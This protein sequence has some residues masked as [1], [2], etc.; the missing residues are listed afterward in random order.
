MILI[1]KRQKK[2]LSGAMRYANSTVYTRAN[3]FPEYKGMG[4]TADICLFAFDT[5]YICHV[6]DGRVYL[7][8]DGGLTRLT[9]DHTLIEELLKNG[10][11]TEEEAKAHPNRHIITR[12]VGTDEKVEG[13]FTDIR[14]CDGDTV[15]MCTDGLT[16]MLSNEDIMDCL[17][18]GEPERICNELIFRS[19]E[20]GGRD[21]ITAV[22]IKYQTDEEEK[23]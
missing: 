9:T 15:L 22:V 8:R 10:T 17:S 5:L 13:D 18:L 3:A 11:I 23:N 12:A 19:N 16:N 20:N 1:G 2:L 6:G 21:N 14:L 4:T 7:F